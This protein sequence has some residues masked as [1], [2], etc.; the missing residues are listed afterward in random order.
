M[1]RV[2]TVTLSLIL[3]A[4]HLSCIAQLQ[5]LYTFQKDD[6]VLRKKYAE[7]SIKKKELLLAAAGKENAKEYK[8]IYRQQFESI[9]ELW[10][11][12]RPV[13]SPEAHDYLQ[14]ILQKI[15]AVNPELKGTDVRLVFSRDWWPNAVSMGDGTIAINAGLLVYMDNEAELVF[16]VCH[17]LAHYYLEHTQKAIKKYVETINSDAYQAELKRLSKQQYNVN[18]QVEQ[19][20]MTTMFNVR[21]HS[22][23]NEAAADKQAL[24]FMKKTGYDCNAIISTLEL[25]DRVDDSLFH[26]PINP[27]Q[28]FNFTGYPFKKKWIQ[29]ESSIFSQVDDHSSFSKKEKD[30]LKTHPDCSRRISLLADSVHSLAAGG[31]KFIVNEELFRKLKRDF[32]IEIAEECYRENELSRNLYYNLVLL[33]EGKNRPLTVYSVT[34][35]L[36]R[37]YEKQQDH[38]FG[39]AVDTEN[40]NYPADY[41]LLL[42][43]L[44]RLRLEEIASISYYF[45]KQYEQEMKGHAGFEKEMAKAARFKDQ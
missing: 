41:N 19:L 3:F 5:S 13:T 30:S 11:S 45:C 21:R 35:C 44:G 7:Q 1:L 8:E 28:V 10:N 34:R 23:E 27:E 12:T 14:A 25:L 29:N 18:R 22:R 2:R 16:V 26:Q 33:Q 31:K 32:F 39:T 17:E 38:K 43:M 24:L 4:F 36:N 15:I 20:A 6:T 9:G 40:K 42:R 37:L